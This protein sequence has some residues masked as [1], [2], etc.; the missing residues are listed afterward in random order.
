MYGVLSDIPNV[1]DRLSFVKKCYEKFLQRSK[2]LLQKA[3]QEFRDDRLA[4]LTDMSLE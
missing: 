2:L 3:F 4:V 1:T